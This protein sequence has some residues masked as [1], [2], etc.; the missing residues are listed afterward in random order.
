MNGEFGRDGRDQPNCF[1][2]PTTLETTLT[3][4][5]EFFS[6]RES[7]D[8]VDLYDT[9]KLPCKELREMMST[10]AEIKNPLG[11]DILDVVKKTEMSLSTL[12]NAL[13]RD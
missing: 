13:F 10:I 9:A 4:M 11:S 12:L 3:S 2:G 8:S 5:A 6:Q 7:D 1:Q